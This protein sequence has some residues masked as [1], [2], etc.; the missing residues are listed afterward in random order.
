MDSVHN[1]QSIAILSFYYI[2]QS[3]KLYSGHYFNNHFI[4]FQIFILKNI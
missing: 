2:D 3:N 1:L 4:P